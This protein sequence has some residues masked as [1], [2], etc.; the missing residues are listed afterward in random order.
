[1]ISFGE[2]CHCCEVVLVAFCASTD[3]PMKVPRQ[4]LGNDVD[5]VD[6]D[7]V[8]VGLGVD[9]SFPDS[10]QTAPAAFPC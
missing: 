2:L 9:Q 7:H 8:E 4:H 1:M 6:V 10:L 5:H 3:Y